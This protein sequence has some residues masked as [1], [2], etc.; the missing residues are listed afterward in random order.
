[1]ILYSE[2]YSFL[3]DSFISL[4]LSVTRGIPTPL[5]W[6]FFATATTL[7]GAL[8]IPFWPTTRTVFT[9]TMPEKISSIGTIIGI[10][11]E[12]CLAGVGIFASDAFP[13][14]HGL[15]TLLFFTLFAI[16]IELYSIV[17]INNNKEYGYLYDLFGYL[18]CTILFLH[19]FVISDAA[20]QKLTVY[21]IIL[22]SVIQGYKLLKLFQ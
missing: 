12:P 3:E 19:I 21:T 8:S 7:A 20:M 13:F 6:F 22:Y 5:N 15:S 10:I 9:D 11:A 1:M 18:T 17:I 16:A 14:Q 4:G 2:G